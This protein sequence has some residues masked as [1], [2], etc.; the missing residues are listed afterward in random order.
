MNSLDAGRRRLRLIDWR[1]KC[2]GR[3]ELGRYLGIEGLLT[4]LP[5]NGYPIRACLT[6]WTMV[7]ALGLYEERFGRVLHTGFLLI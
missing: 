2:D 6:P 7:N 5:R 3:R 4:M 1:G